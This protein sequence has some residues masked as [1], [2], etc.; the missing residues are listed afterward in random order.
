MA[1][2][3]GVVAAGGPG[4]DP[5]PGLPG[6]VMKPPAWLG[7]GSPFDVGAFFRQVPDDRNAAALYLDAL[8]EFDPAMAVC[9]PPGAERDRREAAARLRSRHFGEL[10][11]A[12]QNDAG[13]VS[14]EQIDAVAGAYDEGFAKLARA[15]ERPDCVFDSGLDITAQIPHATAARQV[16]RIAALRARRQ[17]EQG[18]LIHASRELSRVLR[19]AR[20]LVP[21]GPLVTD[22]ASIGVERTA[23]DEI[24]MPLL[25]D[26]NL[27]VS[28]CDRLLGILVEHDAKSIDRYAEGLRA[29]YVFSRGTLRALVQDQDRLRRDWKALGGD[30]GPSIA[31]AIAEPQLISV[32]AGGGAAPKALAADG[33]G[34]RPA[35]L[36]A[37]ADL[38]A[39]MA[40]MPPEEL[41]RQEALLGAF[42]RDRLSLAEMPYA[43]R[44]RR[45]DSMPPVFVADDVYTRV[46]KGLTSG[47]FGAAIA[48]MAFHQAR[49]RDAIG[50][51]AVRRWQLR[52]DGQSPPSLDAAAKDAGLVSVPVDPYSG[53]PV[54][55]AIIAGRPVVYCVG[56]DGQDGGGRA[57]AKVHQREGD[58]ILRMPESR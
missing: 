48:S 27:T 5:Q 41:A 28:H 16:A 21:R 25:A 6:A 29:E 55:L 53:G 4:L 10:L 19:L 22:L 26:R 34:A 57:E 50:L 31:A 54:R 37:A 14:A 13:S 7:A 15:Q 32:L 44:M 33:P 58:V 43:E 47:A 23:V 56:G 46:T 39:A 45:L 40:R 12:R 51:V 8:F 17:L 3:A 2:L 18:S 9:F 35:S 52:H 49:L 11:T 1:V 30:P 20:D 42:F 36:R 38:D 24:A